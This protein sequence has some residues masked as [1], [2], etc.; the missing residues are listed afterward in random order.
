[1]EE[2]IHSQS[3][4]LHRSRPSGAGW[5]LD[6][7]RELRGNLTWSKG[8]WS[9]LHVVDTS[10]FTT[11]YIGVLT[12]QARVKAKMETTHFE[13]LFRASYGL[14]R[15]VLEVINENIRHERWKTKPYDRDDPFKEV[16]RGNMCLQLNTDS[17]C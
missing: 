9:D 16:S 6:R 1:M 10:V 11:F 3:W 15:H 8:G 4:R 13:I 17:A 12:N 14:D 7:A 2:R 5:D